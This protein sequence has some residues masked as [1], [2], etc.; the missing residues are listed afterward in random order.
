MCV[1]PSQMVASAPALAVAEPLIVMV[2][3]LTTAVEQPLFG[4]AVRVKVMIPVSPA[5]G[6]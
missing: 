5:P 4:C 6:V 3:V 1:D 2:I